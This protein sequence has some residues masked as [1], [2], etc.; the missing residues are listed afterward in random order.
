MD[1]ERE[2]R[3]KAEQ[4]AR[5]LITHIRL[6]QASGEHICYHCTVTMDTIEEEQRRKHERALSRVMM[7]ERDIIT[8]RETSQA[9]IE[10]G[11]QLKVIVIIICTLLLCNG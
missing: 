11:R 10:E 1:S 8:E 6:L 5:K 4:A 3:W 7:L 2:Q 9:H